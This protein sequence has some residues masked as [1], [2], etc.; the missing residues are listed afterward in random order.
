MLRAILLLMH[1]SQG[2]VQ[3]KDS[4]GSVRT[5]QC[6]RA[7]GLLGAKPEKNLTLFMERI[8]PALVRIRTADDVVEMLRRGAVG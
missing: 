8:F 3:E 7:Y 6:P 5:R 4:I 1:E 2:S